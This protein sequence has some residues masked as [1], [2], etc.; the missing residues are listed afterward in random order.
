MPR[1]RTIPLEE[2]FWSKVH[3]TPTCWLWT[4]TRRPGGYGTYYIDRYPALA[5]RVAWELANSQ[6]VPT[7][8]Y[9][10]HYCDNPPCVR[11]EH[12][13]L[14]T[15]ADNMHDAQRKGRKAINPR[16]RGRGRAVGERVNT[17]R[18]TAEDVVEIRQRAAEGKVDMTA[19]GREYGVT[20]NNIRYVIARK[21]WKHIP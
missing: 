7:G 6:L 8:K 1:K 11:P 21:T 14:G 20:A 4:A 17:S 13:F 16:I 18:L 5:H 2:H 9:V 10:L 15:A 12:L 3:K 19:L